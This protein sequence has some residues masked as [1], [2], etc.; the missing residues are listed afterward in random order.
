MGI[1]GTFSHYVYRSTFSFLQISENPSNAFLVKVSARSWHFLRVEYKI[2][3]HQFLEIFWTS[4][5][6]FDYVTA[7]TKWALLR[8]NFQPQRS[9]NNSLVSLTSMSLCLVRISSSP[10][11]C[12]SSSYPYLLRCLLIKLY[13]FCFLFHT[14]F[15]KIVFTFIM[16]PCHGVYWCVHSLGH[17]PRTKSI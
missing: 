11:V 8:V 12:L 14:V 3:L 1:F 2:C 13:L 10:L 5:S 16:Y 15:I 7:P 17:I 9:T 6:N 4:L